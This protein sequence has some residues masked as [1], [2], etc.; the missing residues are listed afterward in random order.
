MSACVFKNLWIFIPIRDL[1]HTPQLPPDIGSAALAAPRPCDH[2]P[3]CLARA[4]SLPGLADILG[5]PADGIVKV[6]LGIVPVC[7]SYRKSRKSSLKIAC[8]I[9]ESV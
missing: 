4:A 5:Y 9:I 1:P 3:A 7:Q 8:R 6:N 2:A